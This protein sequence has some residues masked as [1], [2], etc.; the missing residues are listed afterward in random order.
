M[1]T[2]FGA[3]VT[4]LLTVTTVQAQSSARH[5]SAPRL[6]DREDLDRLNLVKD[7][8]VY[9]P[10]DGRRDGIAHVELLN[11]QLV[12]LLRSGLLVSVDRTTGAR[13]WQ[14]HVGIPYIA[15]AG[16]TA[17]NKLIFVAKGINI[18]AYRRGSGNLAWE[19]SL[20]HSPSASPVADE[21]RLY[22][23]L[24]TNR[25]HAYLL[26]DLG[27][28]KASP[29]AVAEVDR[30][31][32]LVQPNARVNSQTDPYRRVSSRFASGITGQATQSV[33]A[34]S[35]GGQSVRSIGPLSSAFEA[36]QTGAIVGPQP[37]YLWDYITETQP[38]TRIEQSSI[39]TGN[40]ICQAGANGLFFVLS[41][42]EPRIFYRYQADASVSAP[43]GGWGEIAYVPS[44]D[45]RVYAMDI[46]NGK[47]LWRFVGGGP[48]RQKP[49][50][51][52]SSVYVSAEG[53]G[54]YRLDRINSGD[55]LWRNAAA[56]RF[57]AANDK[58]VY[59]MDGNNRLLILDQTRGT[60]LAVYDGTR[61]F[62]YPIGNEVT[63]RIYLASN[64]GLVV[65]LHDRSYPRPV[66][67]K[68]EPELKPTVPTRE[69]TKPKPAPKAA[70][71]KKAKKEKDEGE[72]T[73][74]DK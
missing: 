18:Y 4:V 73:S 13:Q 47:I 41:K 16:M 51:T 27:A 29:E 46:V 37:A 55:T 26:P 58:F 64:D 17:N 31:D 22:I 65:S 63:D 72:G 6:P 56:H 28:P 36:R 14:T 12:F 15:A 9:L 49:W 67:M 11:K 23:P 25:M 71:S 42:F 61:D 34:V 19:F 66:L 59:A 21:E 74:A 62:L 60:Q 8:H 24:G 3:L 2:L 57:L 48:I 1:R 54:L 20:P 38:E 10:M 7:W 70:P 43:I 33:S 50:V 69:E 44:D 52:D 53:A 30:K 39:L 32:R 5:F 45:F 35:S 40:Y 68:K